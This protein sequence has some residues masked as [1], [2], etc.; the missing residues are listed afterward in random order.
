MKARLAWAAARLLALSLLGCGSNSLPVG[1]ASGGTTGAIADAGGEGGH[2]TGG[3]GGVGGGGQ[4]ASPD[5]TA[6]VAR[7]GSDAD[8]GVPVFACLPGGEDRLV[9]R[10][11]SGGKALL[12]VTAPEKDSCA[13]RYHPAEG[14]DPASLDLSWSGQGGLFVVVRTHGVAPGQTGTF[15]P[16]A[17]LINQS[18]AGWIGAM[19]RCRVTLTASAKIGEETVDSSLV[20]DVFKVAGGVTCTAWFPDRPGEVLERFEFTTR[21]VLLRPP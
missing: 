7:S 18:S 9:I 17:V 15:T 12:D 5:V 21:S 4:D 16:Y 10:I 20:R 13:S 1:D 3:A 11:V 19:D 8:V 6:D 14:G 2:P